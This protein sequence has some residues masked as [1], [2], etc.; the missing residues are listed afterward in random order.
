MKEIPY[1]L[2]CRLIELIRATG[3]VTRVIWPHSSPPP[4]T[5]RDR[6]K[7]RKGIALDRVAV[8]FPRVSSRRPD[9]L[10]CHRSC[11]WQQ[12]TL[13]SMSSP[14]RMDQL[15]P[16]DRRKGSPSPLTTITVRS[17]LKSFAPVERRSAFHAACGGVSIVSGSGIQAA[18]RYRTQKSILSM[19]NFNSS[20]PPQYPDPYQSSPP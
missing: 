2:N 14:R 20:L 1:V 8:F 3:W 11:C 6:S 7:G 12:I 15:I 18:H 4:I 13:M 16:S 17:G 9:R 5:R 19:S 10:S